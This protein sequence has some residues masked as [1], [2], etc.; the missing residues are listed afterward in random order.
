MIETTNHS[1]K[2]LLTRLYREYI[3][4]YNR[5][6]ILAVCCMILAGI[7]TAANAYMMK[8]VLDDI[9][10]NRD[11]NKL[12]IIPALIILI[13]F[14]G[15][16]ANYFHTLYM[17]YVG[18]RI[19]ADMQMH[20][21]AHLLKSDLRLFHDQSSGRLISRFTNDIQM[22]RNAVSSTLTAIAKEFI[23]M[24]CLIG[25][26]VYQSA[27]LALMAF[28]AFPLAIYPLMRFGKR[29]RKISNQTQAELG[30]F[31][32]QLDDI[33]Q[34]VK[35]V[36]SYNREAFEVERAN[37]TITRLFNLYFKAA[38][39]QTVSSPV[40]EM[41]SGLVIA[42]VIGYG[43]WQVIYQGMSP[44][45]FFSFIAAFIMAYR[46]VKALAGLN[47]VMQEGLASANRL[48]N[49][50]DTAPEIMDAPT[51]PVLQ[52]Q[53]GDVMFERVS[54]H[55]AENAGG[56]D[57]VDIQI[58]AGSKVALV[59]QSGGGKTTLMNLLMRFYDPDSGRILIDGQDIKSVTQSSLREVL[60]YVPQEPMLFDDTVAANIGY[61]KI[62]SSQ[63][64]IEE[65]AKLAA[66]HDFIIALPEG[67]ATMIG[68]HGVKLSGGQRQRLAIARA[69]L[70]NAPIL[71]L[72]EATSALDNESER[73]VQ[74]ALNT[75]MQ[76]RTTLMIAHRLTTIQHADQIYVLEQ[77]RVVEQGNHETLLAK[78]GAYFALQQ[79]SKS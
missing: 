54:F 53:R 36:K 72:D 74:Q 13:F 42:G 17:R 65:A 78:Q 71:L 62:G 33:F 28:V 19:I 6:I 76:N 35:T 39:V 3:S 4:R 26:M 16:V 79:A 38:R 47:N 40:M 30:E 50:L 48:F 61:G 5:K 31:T 77:G 22:M 66:A 21:F 68:S 60:A 8:P 25:V 46:P 41:I 49:V 64:E 57:A 43:G 23:T 27:E 14:V 70:K 11:H 73:L 29:T 44:G 63:A 1:S 51:A 7:T 69:M 12:F 18:S 52:Y 67:Y 32:A 55:Y 20:L 2:T 15:S 34:G 10:I 58:K 45:A 59:G 24:V 56:V 37:A 9:F 75:L